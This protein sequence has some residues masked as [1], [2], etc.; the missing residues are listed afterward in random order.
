M[1][2]PSIQITPASTNLS[3]ARLNVHVNLISVSSRIT[4]INPRTMRSRRSRPRSPVRWPCRN[5]DVPAK[6]TNAG[7]QKCVTQRVK[8]TAAVGP[9]AGTPA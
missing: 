4:S 7:A 8:N 6:K 5:A 9:P 2:Q 1:H 3:S